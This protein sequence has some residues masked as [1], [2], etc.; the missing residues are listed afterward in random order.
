MSR[1]PCRPPPR[2]AVSSSLPRVDLSRSGSPCPAD[3][4]RGR[5]RPPGRALRHRTTA[6][7]AAPGFLGLAGSRGALAP[8]EGAIPRSP[9]VRPRQERGERMRPASRSVVPGVRW[10]LCWG[11][12]PIPSDAAVR[13]GAP[14]PVPA[15]PPA[16]LPARRPTRCPR[17]GTAPSAWRRTRTGRP[18]FWC[19]ED[20]TPASPSCWFLGTDKEDG[21]PVGR[22]SLEGVVFPLPLKPAEDPLRGLNRGPR[23]R[24]ARRAPRGRPR[25]GRDSAELPAGSGGGVFPWICSSPENPA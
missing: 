24:R 20:G 11:W 8:H 12:V 13:S 10:P 2:E 6:A 18:P 25:C 15:H 4:P 5:P 22:C 1:S 9:R 3:A 21:W 17:T 23:R 19:T 7:A 16:H 14:P